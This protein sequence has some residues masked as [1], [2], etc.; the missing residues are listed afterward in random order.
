MVTVPIDFRIICVF[1]LIF[2]GGGN[3]Y[4]LSAIRTV[5]KDSLKSWEKNHEKAAARSSCIRNALRLPD[6][7]GH[8][9]GNY[10]RN[11]PGCRRTSGYVGLTS[12]RAAGAGR[13]AR[14]GRGGD[15]RPAAKKTPAKPTEVDLLT[16]QARKL[17]AKG[18]EGTQDAARLAQQVSDKFAAADPAKLDMKNWLEI[19]SSLSKYYPDAT[20]TAMADAIV[21]QIATDGTAIGKMDEK[22]FL[23]VR[24][25]LLKLGSEAAAQGTTAKWVT[26]SEAYKAAKP[27]T[28]MVLS[29][30][31][32]AAK[33]AG[34]EA[35][36]KLAALLSD[37]WQKDGPTII[38]IGG[39]W[40][41]FYSNIGDALSAD[42]K[43]AWA[44]KIAEAIVSDATADESKLKDDELDP[45]VGTVKKLDAKQAL[46]LAKEVISNDGLLPKARTSAILSM[47]H[48]LAKEDKDSL[49]KNMEAIHAELDAR[50]AKKPLAL[51]DSIAIAELVLEY[52]E[53]SPKAQIWMVRAADTAFATE[54]TRAG[55]DVGKIFL[56]AKTLSLIDLPA[57]GKSQPGYAEVLANLVKTG[58]VSEPADSWI[59]AAERAKLMARLLRSPEER[60]LLRDQVAAENGSPRSVAAKILSF[61]YRDPKEIEE[62]KAFLDEKASAGGDKGLEWAMERAFAEATDGCQCKPLAGRKWLDQVVKG[63]QSEDLR[64][65]AASAL[66][67]GFIS[68]DKYDEGTAFLAE[69]AGRF[70][71][72]KYIKG[73]ATLRDLTAEVKGSYLKDEIAALSANAA[74][75]EAKAQAETDPSHKKLYTKWAV[76]GRRREAELRSQQKTT[77][78]APAAG[79]TQ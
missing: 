72:E 61:A 3:L 62:W 2:R 22:T 44:K 52:G 57:N 10:R 67:Y 73:L 34:K 51:T 15:S 21:K 6:P 8:R 33:D 42:Q 9:P 13:D 24:N 49:L 38:S 30:D 25:T 19:C 70:T 7:A 77:T 45:L 75:M 68:D 64:Y 11:R 55:I 74:K 39:R 23:R 63:A 32:K 4:S 69:M 48:W 35:R 28:L 50:A 71:Q 37:T 56:L 65:L 1:R 79:I 66:G 20:K 16:A 46:A 40:A 5:K 36:T 12:P 29:D 27:P 26:N 78:T 18:E 59:S 41:A 31:A 58:K 54:K 47:A 53:D 17:I 76:E 43:A 60:Q 14:P